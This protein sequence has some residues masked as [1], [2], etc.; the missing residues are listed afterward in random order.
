M[1]EQMHLPVLGAISG[2]LRWIE[3]L[4]VLLSGPMLT[5]GLLIGLVSLLSDGRLLLTMPWLLYAWAISQ[6]VGVDGQLVGAWFRVS[7]VLSSSTLSWGRKLLAVAALVTLGLTLAYVAYVA[8]LIFSMQQGYG[9][10]VAQALARLGMDSATWLWQR[11][12]ISVFLV[13]LS[14]ASRYRKKPVDRRNLAEKTRAIEEQMALDALKQRQQAQRL[15]GMVGAVRGAV[16]AATASDSAESSDETDVA[17]GL[18]PAPAGVLV[19]EGA[20]APPLSR[21]R[22]WTSE[23]YSRRDAQMQ[24]LGMTPSPARTR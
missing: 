15:R 12:A 7:V 20:D 16:T 18:V 23:E 1:D 14:G 10:T 4:I 9:L 19:V 24:A 22:T 13:C 5:A 8:A 17:S 6:A 3:E 21:G 11:A 2:F